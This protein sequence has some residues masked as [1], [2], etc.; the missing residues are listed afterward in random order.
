MQLATS[1]GEQLAASERRAEEMD[2]RMS[3]MMEQQARML[4]ILAANP[5]VL[6]AATSGESTERALAQQDP[7]L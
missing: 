1:T 2:K 3:V 5:K 7:E 6:S 4:E